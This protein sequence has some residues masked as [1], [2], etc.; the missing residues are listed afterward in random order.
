MRRLWGR[1]EPRRDVRSHGSRRDGH[2]KRPARIRV[3]ACAARRRICRERIRRADERD[4]EESDHRANELGSSQSAPE[5]PY[6][7]VARDRVSRPRIDHSACG[8]EPAGQ[9]SRHRRALRGGPATDR[10]GISRV[11]CVT[12]NSEHGRGYSGCGDTTSTAGAGE[13]RPCRRC[14]AITEP[15]SSAQSARTNA[16]KL[17]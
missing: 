17:K 16:L 4:S 14:T 13:R 11:P 10:D 6:V 5:K 12:R 2:G 15:P 8:A 3:A 1:R 7:C 9:I